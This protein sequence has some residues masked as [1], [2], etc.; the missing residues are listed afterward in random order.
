MYRVAR[1]RKGNA[2]LHMVPESAVTACGLGFVF[3]TLSSHV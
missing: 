3:A 1:S 2:V